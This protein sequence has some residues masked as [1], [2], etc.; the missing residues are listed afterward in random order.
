MSTSISLISLFNSRDIADTIFDLLDVATI[1]GIAP[2]C[3]RL[4]ELSKNY[5]E[6]RMQ[7]DILIPAKKSYNEFY[8]KTLKMY[9]SNKCQYI[10]HFT[11]QI[12]NFI[13]ML[14]EFERFITPFLNHNNYWI[15]FVYDLK[16]ME[17][18]FLFV[19]R[20]NQMMEYHK[21]KLFF[22][23]NVPND[24]KDLY[25]KLQKIFDNIDTYLYVDYP[26]RF[27]NVELHRMARF[28]KIKNQYKMRRTSLIK[29]MQRPFDEVYYFQ[30]DDHLCAC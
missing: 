1:S 30:Y 16:I 17:D 19:S 29:E 21:E 25:F 14:N 6:T 9:L 18:M 5:Y 26:D 11:V 27:L 4:A 15:L 7:K 3:K 13:N 20:I 28:K 23:P 24:Q 10:L 8:E 22:Y 2:V 12:R